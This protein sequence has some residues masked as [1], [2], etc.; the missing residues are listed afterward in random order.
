MNVGDDVGLFFVSFVVIT[1][2]TTGLVDL[3][4]SLRDPLRFT[5]PLSL[6][7]SLSLIIWRRY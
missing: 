6:I 3:T 1:C 4:K 2:L 5:I 7:I